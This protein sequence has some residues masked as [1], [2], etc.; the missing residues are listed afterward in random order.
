MVNYLNRYSATYAHHYALLSAL[1]HQ[2][3]DY[4]PGKGHFEHFNKLKME[5][6]KMRALPYLQ[7]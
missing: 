2:A 6:S 4:K 5:V 1:T 3:V 7:K